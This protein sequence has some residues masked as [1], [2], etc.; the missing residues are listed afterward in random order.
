MIA[1]RLKVFISHTV[2]DPR[3]RALAHTIADG[4]RA[5]GCDVWIAPETIPVGDQ[6]EE[7]I[8]QGILTQCSHFLVLL[9]AASTRSQPVLDEIGLARRRAEKAPPFRILPLW[10]GEPRRF[11]H[12]KSLK[13]LQSLPYLE[14]SD[15]QVEAVASAV[16]V[17]PSLPASYADLL[18]DPEGGFVGRG[19]VFAAIDRFTADQAK[20]Y[21]TILGDP[22]AGKSTLLAEL[23]R[24]KGCVA[25]FNSRA[26]GV[27]SAQAFVESVCRQLAIRFGLHSALSWSMQRGGEQLQETLGA[28]AKAVARGVATRPLLIGVD[29]LDE[30]AE[31]EQQTGAN[32]LFLPQVVPE[33]LYFIVTRRRATVPLVSISPQV[34]FDLSDY[35]EENRRDIEAYLEAAARRDRLASWLAT[36]RI[37]T[38]DFVGVLREKSELNFMYAHYVVQALESGF[39]GDLGLDHLPAGLQGYYEDH[40]RR[41]GMQRSPLPQ[42]KIRILYVLSELSR[43]A[44]LAEII[45]FASDS[46]LRLDPVDAAQ[47]LVEWEPF[48]R[49]HPAGGETRYSLYHE[50]FRDFLHR[51][52]IVQAAGITLGDVRDRIAASLWSELIPEL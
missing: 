39:Y 33:G 9:S 49:R 20:G 15:R 10:I 12:E 2:R 4:L 41:M 18:G 35:P 17:V 30:V 3:D 38:N 44:S 29:A 47:V 34:L 32:V 48:L 52:E 36:R 14:S 28:V 42:E 31:A 46:S 11:I 37:G 5:R 23:V 27:T 45:R 43:P 13:A 24:R 22:G 8:I 25:H 6:W 7:A 40:W 26:G 50:S 51:K 1:E 16:G 19:H 21:F